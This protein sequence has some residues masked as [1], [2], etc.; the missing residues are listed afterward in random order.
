[1]LLDL[2]IQLAF[3]LGQ[4]YQN[5]YN[6]IGLDMGR[7][8]KYENVEITKGI[9]SREANARGDVRLCMTI[10]FI[11]FKSEADREFLANNIKGVRDIFNDALKELGV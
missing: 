4:A 11:D 2:L 3:E 6:Q 10:K 7:K 1:M 5:I 8:K 9:L